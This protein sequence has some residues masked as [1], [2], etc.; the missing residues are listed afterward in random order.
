MNSIDHFAAE[1]P[2]RGPA[3]AG[4][5]AWVDLSAGRIEY[6]DLPEPALRQFLG[7]RGLNAWLLARHLR[8]DADPLGPDNVL[9]FSNGLLTGTAAPSSSRLHVGARSPLTGLLGSS[10][11]GSYVGAALRCAGIQSLV[12]VG[13]APQP[14]NLW[15][16]REGVELRDA[17]GLWGLDTRAA[18][19]ALL[20]GAPGS[21]LMVI[22]PAGE[23]LVRYACIV[24]DTRHAAGRTGMGA[25]MGAKNLKAIVLAAERAPAAPSG[26]GHAAIRDYAARIRGAPRYA[27]YARFSNSAFVNW[28]NQAG[29]LATRNSRGVNFAGA[30]RIDGEQLIR[31]VT[32]ARTCHRC[33]VHCKA[34]IEIAGGPYAGTRGERPDIEPIMGLGARCGLDDP[35]A[36]LYLYNL[37]TTLGLDTISTAGV[38]A[39]AMELYERGIITLQDTDGIALNWGDA[40]AMQQMMQRIAYRQGFGAILAEGVRRAAQLIGRAAE[41]YAL[42]SKGLELTGYDPRGG[43][44][45]ALGYAVS[46]RGGDFTSIYPV[47]EYRWSA[48]EG[49]AWFGDARAVDR[50]SPAGKGRLVRR[51]MIVSATLDALGLCKVPAL[52]VV[53]DFSLTGEATLTSALTGWNLSADD[54]ALAG[55]RVVTLEKLLNL[56]LGA[57]RADDDLPD[58]FTEEPVLDAGPTRGMTV[59]I[60]PMRR[61]FYNAMGWDREGTP[62]PATLAR[63]GLEADWPDEENTPT[64]PPAPETA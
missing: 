30:E 21:R 63:L 39:F 23:N 13:R 32:R 38:L 40:G 6:Q 41:A 17:A 57:G 31:Y 33:P 15:I 42:H 49:Q 22:G 27:T 20:A 52:S 58:R 26:A 48:E 7:G 50:L 8:R 1:D 16:S 44:G 5:L 24:T 4:K 64:A 51:T 28:A 3:S 61:D 55:E 36:L 12:I 35:E 54:L 62:T 11:V 37:T 9:V 19:A 29:I 46:L 56:R 34:E 59:D 45:T 25:V 18:T 53:G 43:L 14:V 10:N 47:P 2:E 60:Q